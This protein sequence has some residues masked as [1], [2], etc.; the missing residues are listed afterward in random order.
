M[1]A[2]AKAEVRTREITAIVSAENA[3][4]KHRN[5]RDFHFARDVDR[6]AGRTGCDH[7]QRHGNDFS[8]QALVR[9]G[10][11]GVKGTYSASPAIE[12]I[13]SV[14]PSVRCSRLVPS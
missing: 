7:L 10:A 12:Y 5:Q 8:V 11:D 4:L 2:A 14:V 1:D 13:A 9:T 3:K 6:G